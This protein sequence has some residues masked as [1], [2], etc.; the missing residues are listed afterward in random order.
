MAIELYLEQNTPLAL[1]A[2]DIISS[3]WQ[4]WFEI[5]AEQ[6]TPQ[7]LLSGEYEVTLRLTDDQEMQGLN[8]QFRQQDRTTD[9]LAFAALESDLPLT[10]PIFAHQADQEEEI[11]EEPVYLGDII[12]SVPQAIAQ[13]KDMGHSEKQELIWLAA[14]G[15]LHLLG[16]DHPDQESLEKMLRQQTVLLDCLAL[17]FT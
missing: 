6:L 13:A 16:W 2:G 3:H 7:S 12:I 4:K 14:H 1:A 10:N 11:L 17:E 9:V 8:A 15:F 5:W